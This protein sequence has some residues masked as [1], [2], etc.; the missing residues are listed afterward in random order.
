MTLAEQQEDY[1][2]TDNELIKIKRDLKESHEKV[3]ALEEVTLKFT[4]SFLV[5]NESVLS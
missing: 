2:S 5:F 4:F 1:E 3:A